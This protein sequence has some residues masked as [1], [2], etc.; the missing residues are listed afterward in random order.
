MKA[1]PNNMDWGLNVP[2]DKRAHKPDEMECFTCHL[3][4]TT[5]CGGCHL[6]IE[7]NWKT[8]RHHYEGG[9]TRNYATYN[10]Q[11]A[12]DQMFQL[13]IHSTAKGN[14]IAPIRSTS[15]LVLSST[16][17]N[18]ENFTYNNRRSH[19][20]D[21]LAKHSRLTS[22]IQLGKKRPKIVPTAIYLLLMTI[23]QEWLNSYCRVQ[24]L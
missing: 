5:S 15:A 20:V 4:W 7:A 23:M 16:N 19:L 12:R 8:E 2:A 11:V 14:T 10:P 17:I 9:E 21:I 24:I 1:D 13:G 3:S 18:R 22:H 6:P